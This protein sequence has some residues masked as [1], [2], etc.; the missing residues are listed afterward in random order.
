MG[1]LPNSS[2]ACSR[3]CTLEKEHT[4]GNL[5][6]RGQANQE[7]KQWLLEPSVEKDKTVFCTSALPLLLVVEE[8]FEKGKSLVVLSAPSCWTAPPFVPASA[9]SQE[10]RCGARLRRGRKRQG[11]SAGTGRQDRP[12]H[13]PPPPSPSGPEP[14]PVMEGGS[15]EA[16]GSPLPRRAAPP[17][18]AQRAGPRLPARLPAPLPPSPRSLARSPLP[19]PL[20]SSPGTRS[21]GAPRLRRRRQG[22]GGPTA[23]QAGEGNHPFHYR[24]FS[25][26]PA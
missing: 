21:L 17:A 18:G 14:L 5:R 3:L 2:L 13:P 23:R 6:G 12:P 25:P 24:A 10:E 20:P 22:F 26:N 11:D 15:Q 19:S 7:R 1:S 9:T 8:T 16:A 4:W